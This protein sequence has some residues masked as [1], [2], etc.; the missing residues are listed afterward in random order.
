LSGLV[1]VVIPL[2]NKESYIVATLQS[3]MN[4]T[5]PNIEC[6]IVDDGSTDKSVEIASKF[7]SDY[8]LS[9]SLISQKNSGQTKARNCG[10]HQAKG[11]Y[12]AFL[13]SDD[14]WPANK[15]TLQVEAFE[16]NPKSVLI[17]S[18][19]AIFSEEK[20]ISRVV[21]H[22][23]SKKMNTRWLDMRGFGG[24]LES[25]GLVRKKTLDQI[26]SFDESL[27]TS[28]G[29]DLSLRL[30]KVGKIVLLPGIGL[31]YRLSTGQW[32]T[33]MDPLVK[34][35]EIL[36]HRYGGKRLVRIRKRQASYFYWTNQSN[37]FS[38]EFALQVLRIF[39]TLD[40]EKILLLNS[41]ITRNL[42]AFARGWMTRQE[43]SKFLYPYKVNR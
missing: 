11:E 21:R 1:S 29:L 10:I 14:L 25:L 22:K 42:C 39:L 35:M 12:I 41:L 28:S 6:I 9:W 17:L 32:H 38:R 2:Y 16:D 13:D 33:N 15:I 7:I 27:S 24:G 18:S 40:L 36:A 4:Q 37:R 20:S 8:K 3:V 43:T 31:Y 5:Y 26:G 30:E 34:D 23:K 19:Y